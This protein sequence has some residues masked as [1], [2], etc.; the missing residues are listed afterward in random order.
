MSAALYRVYVWL[1][2]GRQE[3]TGFAN[4]S[5]LAQVSLKLSA[6]FLLVVTIHTWSLIIA[7]SPKFHIRQQTNKIVDESS[8][9]YHSPSL[10]QLYSMELKAAN[11]CYA[12]IKS[13]GLKPVLWHSSTERLVRLATDAENR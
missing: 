7:S 13:G 12:D 6:L 3:F 10:C 9:R 4:R 2:I 8:A 5:Q 11:L 1:A